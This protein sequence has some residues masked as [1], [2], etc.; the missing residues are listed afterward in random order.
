MIFHLAF[1]FGAEIWLFL[2]L[3]G[4]TGLSEE[5]N[6]VFEIWNIQAFLKVKFKKLLSHSS[7][8]LIAALV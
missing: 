8:Y 6:I 1:W 4:R 7:L 2:E 5:N 3:I